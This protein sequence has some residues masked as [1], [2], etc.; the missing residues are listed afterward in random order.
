MH[1]IIAKL[2]A[3]NCESDIN[4]HV[5]TLAYHIHHCLNLVTDVIVSWLLLPMTFPFL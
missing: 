2:G 3:N 5:E 1:G 4:M